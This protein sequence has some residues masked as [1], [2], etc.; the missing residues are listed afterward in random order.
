MTLQ[1]IEDSGSRAANIKRLGKKD[2]STVS[3]RYKCLGTYDDAEVHQQC[4]A[5]FSTNRFYNVEG[6]I[7]LVESYD[8]TH[9]GGDAWEVTAHYESMGLEDAE[10]EQPEPFKRSR[11]FDTTGG[12]AHYSV[13]FEER[14]YGT[15]A[16]DMKKA[17]GVDGDSVNGVD[18][19]VPA[20]QWSESYDVPSTVITA[21]WIRGVAGITGCINDASFRGFE[22]EEVLF[23]G[24]SG[25]QQWD[26][27]KGDGPWSLTFKFSASQNQTDLS[28]GDLTV[29]KKGHDY[30]W[31]TYDKSVANERVI[32]TP[33]HVY[34]TRVYRKANFSGLGIG[35]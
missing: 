22:A 12:T 29:E 20:L 28:V 21:S 7:F 30:L 16:P 32:Q 4:N 10:Q 26:T 25:S 27:E 14:R 2:K 15:N 8:V 6:F 11:Q 19:V 1:W 33:R 5:F 17:I 34:C 3:V 24:C 18:V 31:V 35:T 23:L 13:G 9:L